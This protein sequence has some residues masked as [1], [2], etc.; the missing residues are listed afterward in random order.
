MH[1]TEEMELIIIYL[2]Q[3][4]QIGKQRRKSLLNK[5]PQT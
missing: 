2:Q 4:L 1:D 5:V 3:T